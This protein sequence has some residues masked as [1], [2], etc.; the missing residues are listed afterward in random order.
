MNFT[1]KPIVQIKKIRNGNNYELVCLKCQEV[2]GNILLDVFSVNS[3]K[4]QYQ[5]YGGGNTKKVN[6]MKK[7]MQKKN[8]VQLARLGLKIIKLSK[9]SHLFALYYEKK[10]TQ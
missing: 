3:Q 8:W 4:T 9:K 6:C 10:R 5:Q 7:I 1:K 2:N